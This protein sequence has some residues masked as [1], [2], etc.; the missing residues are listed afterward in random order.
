[1][2]A[3]KGQIT[4]FLSLILTI[5]MSMTF[6]LLE[7]ARIEGAKL[8]ADN[9]VEMGT[10]SAFSEFYLEMF[11]KYDVFAINKGLGSLESQLEN[12]RKTTEKYMDF[13]INPKHEF[14]NI[15]NIWRLCLEESKVVKYGLLTD[16]KG[17]IFKEQ[18]VIGMK[19]T[20]GLEFLKKMAGVFQNIEN[21]QK[22]G[23]LYN[24]N[25]RQ[26]NLELKKYEQQIDEERAKE[27]E[28]LKE[29]PE[30]EKEQS[31]MIPLMESPFINGLQILE[32]AGRG[33]RSR[34]EDIEDRELFPDSMN[35]EA[36]LSI[37]KN[38]K[39]DNMKNG[40]DLKGFMENPL[41]SIGEAKKKG[42]LQLVC[43][44]PKALSSKEIELSEMPSN[45]VLEEGTSAYYGEDMNT[46]ANHLLF[47]EYQFDVFHSVVNPARES[48]LS[49]ELEYIIAGKGS[50]VE[51]LKVV[52]NRLLWMREGCNFTYLLGDETRKNTAYELSAAIFGAFQIPGLI[53]A[54]QMALL[55]SW[56]YGESILDIRMLLDGG[57]VPL[58]K[59]TEDWR[60]ELE[61]LGDLAQEFKGG[62]SEVSKKGSGY[63]E[64]LRMLM[65]MEKQQEYS[66][67]SLDLIEMNLRVKNE[68]FRI[69]ESVISY[70][71]QVKWRIPDFYFSLLPGNEY[72]NYNGTRYITNNQYSYGK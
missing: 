17:D 31:E 58:L 15:Q 61:N 28:Q 52:V 21:I 8:Q 48:S 2:K 23:D 69:D 53:E 54:G 65:L 42:I 40:D 12:L 26:V 1:V 6:A 47:Q 5:F 68:K 22:S 3:E 62:E 20:I 45:R 13:N 4:I 55:L 19:K 38:Y 35:E 32:S 59:S 7:S 33:M 72:L 25:E 71:F 51:N 56:A 50:D 11:Q 36:A 49:Y 46:M 70:E 34:K 63:E 9:I 41:E 43:R 67:K 14:V 60:L 30:L 24:E 66:M 29:E 16:H 44:N 10:Y 57:K 64:Y 37:L 39:E 18:I 27:K